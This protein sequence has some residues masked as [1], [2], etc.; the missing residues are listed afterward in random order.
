[1]SMQPPPNGLAS[2]LGLTR[3]V[4]LAPMAGGIGT[5]ALAAAVSEAG[6]LGSL[7]AAYLTPGQIAGAVADLRARTARPFAVNLFAP[8]SL[9]A[10]HPAPP[11]PA[12]VAA[13]A[14]ELAPFC[15][16]LGLA[17]PTLP[18]RAAEDF[19]GQFAAVLEARPTVF[20]FAFGRLDAGQL[21]ALRAR[22]IL[23]IGT[24]TGL[25]EARQLARDGVDAVV[26]QGGAAGGHRGGWEDAGDELADTLDLTRRAAAALDVPVIA[27]GGLMTHA[28]VQAALDAGA[29]L[30][31]CGTAFLRAD[32]AGTSAPYRAALAAGTAPTGL[33]RSFSGR[34]ARGL[35]NALSVAVHAPLP[36]PYQNALTRELR[37][38]GARAGEA[39]VLSLWAGE[40]YRLGRAGTAA[41]LLDDLWPT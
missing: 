11:T 16:A 21:A 39:G 9:P 19:A 32:E 24:A 8:T 14:A 18:A 1:M 15:A 28:D 37:A 22:G 38:A 2:R 30:A 7:G 4:V 5:P 17:P 26:V 40:G 25:D 12:E 33:T 34:P 36:Y 20:S 27:A 41:D 35:V 6:G 13:A 10:G 3:P 29:S 31:Q 23:S